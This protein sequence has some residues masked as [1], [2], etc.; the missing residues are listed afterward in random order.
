MVFFAGTHCPI[1][2]NPPVGSNLVFHPPKGSSLLMTTSD[3]FIG[4]FRRLSDDSFVPDYSAYSPVLPRAIKAH[5]DFGYSRQ[6]FFDGFVPTEPSPSTGKWPVLTITDTLGRVLVRYRLDLTAMTMRITSDLGYLIKEEFINLE[7]GGPLQFVV[8]FNPAKSSF[9]PALNGEEVDPYTVS[10]DGEIFFGDVTLAG[11]LQIT[12]MGFPLIGWY[13]ICGRQRFLYSACGCP[14][15]RRIADEN[16]AV[17]VGTVIEYNCPEG[18]FPAHNMYAPP[19]KLTCRSDGTFAEPKF[20]PTCIDRKLLSISI[21]WL[22]LT[23][24]FE[25]LS[26]SIKTTPPA[27]KYYTLL[28]YA[29]S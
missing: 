6:L 15:Y 11:E 3:E 27:R 25:H 12:Y 17:P 24:N 4:S 9:H 8:K 19:P 1:V 16:P 13:F 26:A 22:S 28:R 10:N 2:P 21:S 14:E 7:L 18:F 23:E 29:R 20:W 5:Q